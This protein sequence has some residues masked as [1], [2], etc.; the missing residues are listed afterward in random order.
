LWFLNRATHPV[1]GNLLSLWSHTLF[2]SEWAEGRKLHNL[3]I[4]I[5]VWNGIGFSSVIYSIWSSDLSHETYNYLV[6]V[7]FTV[8]KEIL[9]AQ[10]LDL[11]TKLSVPSKKW[12]WQIP[13]AILLHST[14]RPWTFPLQKIIFTTREWKC[15][16][17]TIFLSIFLVLISYLYLSLCY[18]PNR[19]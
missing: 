7:T 16:S 9:Q 8:P 19:R 10:T 12:A 3:F 14:T 5:L 17:Y 15:E 6:S 18:V 11:V 1:V 2:S 13:N 4:P